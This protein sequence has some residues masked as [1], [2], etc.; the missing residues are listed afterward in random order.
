MIKIWVIYIFKKLSDTVPW[1]LSLSVYNL[2]S[3]YQIVCIPTVLY[4]IRCY[5]WMLLMYLTKYFK[6]TICIMQGLLAYWL[7]V[8]FLKD[9]N[10]HRSSMFYSVLEIRFRSA[11][12]SNAWKTMIKTVPHIRHSKEK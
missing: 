10:M 3:V 12:N 4:A 8:L 11:E 2:A 7:I 9:K 6:I 1:Y 5:R